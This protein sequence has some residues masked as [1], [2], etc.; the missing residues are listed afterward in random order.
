MRRSLKTTATG[1]LILAVLAGL[2]ALQWRTHAAHKTPFRQTAI[3][4]DDLYMT[5]TPTGTLDP[6]KP[7]NWP[8]WVN[9]ST[10]LRGA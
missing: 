1:V 5:V 2:D 6:G 7:S 9:Q 3:T 4:R 10:D 8:I